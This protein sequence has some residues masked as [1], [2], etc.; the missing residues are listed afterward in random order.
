M[1]SH[2]EPVTN[3]GETKSGLPWPVSTTIGSVRV[4]G[5]GSITDHTRGTGEGLDPQ[6]ARERALVLE[7]AARCLRIAAAW[8]EEHADDLGGYWR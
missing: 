3:W 5:V 6:A 8:V 2:V 1:A 7:H 4:D